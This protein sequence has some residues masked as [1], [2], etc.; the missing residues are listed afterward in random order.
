MGKD[1]PRLTKKVFP[2]GVELLG[3]WGGGALGLLQFTHYRYPGH[4]DFL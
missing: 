2:P 4:T 3:A 1:H